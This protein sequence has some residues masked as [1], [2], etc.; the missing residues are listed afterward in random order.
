MS[1][2]RWP[3]KSVEFVRALVDNAVSNAAAK[4]LDV[5]RLVIAHLQVNQ[6]PKQRRRTFRAHGR[7]NAYMSSPCHVEMTLIEV[8]E[9]VAK[10]ATTVKKGGILALAKMSK[11]RLVRDVRG[12]ARKEAAVPIKK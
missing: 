10:A 11:K 12:A 8:P 1:R 4:S 2:A 9:A 7:I 3:V 6:A 5:E